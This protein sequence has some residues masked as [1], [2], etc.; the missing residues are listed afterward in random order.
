MLKLGFLDA[1]DIVTELEGEG[2][3]EKPFLIKSYDDL[4]YV[5]NMVEGKNGT[6]FAFPYV[7]LALETDLTLP[8]D[9]EPIGGL[10]AGAD[11]VNMGI[12]VL[13]FEGKLDGRNHTLTV[14][15]GGRPLLKYARNTEVKNLNIKG[16]HIKSYGLVEE[17]F[18]DYGT[19]GVYATGC[20][21]T[22]TI[23]NV[24]KVLGEALELFDD[25]KDKKKDF[26]ESNFKGNE[27]TT[28][29]NDALKKILSATDI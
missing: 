21:P 23:D 24:N 3:P 5:K 17:Y 10:R 15:D 6:P 25:F 1:K 20:P 26:D 4:M 22:I 9:W 12:D 8:A 27:Y 11:S 19:D 13:A 28:K 29:T 7:Y 16:S 2:S 18:V 14:A